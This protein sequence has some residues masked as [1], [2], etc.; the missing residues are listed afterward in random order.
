ME[1]KVTEK[2]E[3]TWRLEMDY[4]FMVQVVEDGSCTFSRKYDNAV[5][6]VRVYN[7]FVDHGMCRHQRE[8]VLLEPNGKAH[9][10]IFGY[11]NGVAYV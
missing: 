2:I 5:E 8:I 7:S 4:V 1:I 3:K 10:K 9:A 11:P 6:A